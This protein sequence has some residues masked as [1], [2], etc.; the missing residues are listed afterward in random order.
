MNT[1]HI[2]RKEINMDK[3]ETEGI[4]KFVKK[5]FKK[6]Q[7]FLNSFKISQKLEKEIEEY[8][9]NIVE[10]RDFTLFTIIYYEKEK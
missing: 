10:K 4:I 3:E 6:E 2:I 7:D 1:F 8:I 5:L 9:N